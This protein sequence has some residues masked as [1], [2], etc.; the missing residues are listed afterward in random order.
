[1]MSHPLLI[2]RKPTSQV[3]SV[4]EITNDEEC[5]SVSHRLLG[6]KKKRAHKTESGSL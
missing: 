3:P 2:I 5:E 1:M 4:Y 6:K